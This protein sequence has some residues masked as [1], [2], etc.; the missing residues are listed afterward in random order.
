MARKEGSRTFRLVV[1]NDGSVLW[2]FR[3]KQQALDMRTLQERRDQEKLAMGKLPI[4]KLIIQRWSELD[5]WTN[6]E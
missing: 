3:H 6:A 5:G 1:E 4:G 2:E